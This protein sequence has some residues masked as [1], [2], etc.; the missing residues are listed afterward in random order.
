MIGH[1]IHHEAA[2]VLESLGGD[3]SDFAARQL[4]ARIAAGAD[5]ILTMTKSHRDSVLEVAPQKLHRTFTLPEVARII[6]AHDPQTLADLSPLR[7]Q[8]ASHQAPDVADP[9]GQSSEVF[10]AIGDQIA[11]LLTPVL[12]FFRRVSG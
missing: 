9:I 6:S 12:E 1:P 2:L 3:P 5:L 7:S 4:S 10:A 11:G 8:V